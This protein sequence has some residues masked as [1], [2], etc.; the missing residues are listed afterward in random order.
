MKRQPEGV[1]TGGQFAPDRKAE[2]VST[3]TPAP[4]AYQVHEPDESEQLATLVTKDMDDPMLY[5]INQGDSFSDEQMDDLLAGNVLAVEESIRDRFS[6]YVYDETRSKAE[7]LTNEAYDEGTIDRSWGELDDDEQ[8]EIRYAIEAKD[9]STPVKDLMRE[10]GPQL[11]RT[12]FGSPYQS[13]KNPSSY[14][15]NWMNS[16]PGDG[17][18]NEAFADRVQAVSTILTAK[19]LDTTTPEA[20]EAI[21][22]LVTE[23]PWDYHEGVDVDL[24]TYADLDVV[25][26][27]SDF[28]GGTTTKD[29]AFTNPRI[30]LIDRMNGSGH[31]VEIPGTATVRLT[32]NPDGEPAEKGDRFVMDNAKGNGY[33]WD[34]TAGVVK[35]YYRTETESKTWETQTWPEGTDVT[36]TLAREGVSNV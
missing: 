34:E 11:V 20:Q 10:T 1:P 26:V 18:D 23:G 31:D 4:H 30:L 25:R 6:D 5:Y 15:G 35:S 33:G 27:P 2:P 28:S 32:S 36:N 29:L 19:G 14:S 12:S 7:E 21:E 9:E 22:E 16:Q 13:L 3:L 17:M 8:N 24:I